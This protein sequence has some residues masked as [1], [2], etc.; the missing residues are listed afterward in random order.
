MSRIDQALKIREGVDGAEFVQAGASPSI[1]SSPLNQYPHEEPTPQPRNRPISPPPIEAPKPDRPETTAQ[2]TA[3][4][5]TT[6]STDGDVQARLVTGLSNP[7]SLEQYRKLAVVLH[8]E[9]VQRQLKTV[10]VTSA[11]PHEGKTLTVVNL[12]LTL[13]G[14]YA[15]RVLIIDADLRRPC[16][17]TM[18][19]LQNNRGLS[20]ALR[21]GRDELSFVE[22][23][24]RLS[25]L[26]AGQPGLTP[27]AGLTSVRIGEVIEECAARFDWVLLDTSPVGM[28]PD[29]Q[30]LTR[31]AGGV[32]FVIGAGSTPAAAVERAVA[33]LG[34][35]SIIGTVLNRVEERRIPDVGY[36]NHYNQ[37]NHYHHDVAPHK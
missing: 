26:T 20:E 36:Y 21:D 13:S 28:L 33:D 11:L 27:L 3:T 22:V 37:Y 34:P 23:S 6:R 31:L 15:R 30:V 9:Q 16:L 1:T 35:E 18:F 17:H 10:I 14:S 12:A 24:P 29:A 5:E 32:V 7:V 25:V 4:R 8:E 19:S 2:R